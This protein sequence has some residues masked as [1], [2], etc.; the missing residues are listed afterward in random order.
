MLVWLSLAAPAAILVSR[1]PDGAWSRLRLRP[2]LRR[3]EDRG[4]GGEPP[5]DG[6][7]REPRRPG[8]D[9]VAGAAEL[10]QSR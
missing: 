6:G 4:S 3:C 7:V 8:P 10:D 2:C 1:T 9:P 5:P